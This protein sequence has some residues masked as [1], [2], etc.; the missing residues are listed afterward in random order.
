MSKLI[1]DMA[2]KAKKNTHSFLKTKKGKYS[3]GTYLKY[4]GYALLGIFALLAAILLF[5]LST[6]PL[7]DI[8]NFDKRVIS[9]S[10]KIYDRTGKILLYDN[11]NT[12]RR[13]VVDLDK[14][15]K[16]IANAAISI[17]DD[18][19]Y[20]H[21][22]IRI[23]SIVRAVIYTVF[24]GETQGGSTLTQQIVK[25]TLLTQDQTLSRKIKEAIIALRLEQKLTKDEILEIYLNE[26]PY[27]GNVYGVEE[28]SEVYFNKHASD[29][30]L[31]EA[32]YLASIPQSPY[33]YNPNGEHRD[34][35]DVRAHYVLKRMEEF[36][37]ITK[38][39]HAAAL[40]EDVYF[41]PK[42]Q[43]AVKAPHFVFY[44]RD[45]LEKKYGIERVDKEGLKVTSTLDFELQSV[46]EEEAKKEGLKNEKD[47]GGENVALVAIEPSSG[48]ILAM[49][50]SRDFFD[51]EIDGQFNVAT[52]ARQPGSSFKPFVYAT[53]FKKGYR[54]ET[55]LFDVFTE[56]NAN[57]TATGSGND[58][59]SPENFDAKFKGPMMLKNALAESRNIPAVKLLYLAGIQD[60]IATAK[61]MGITTLNNPKLYGLSLVLGAGEVKPIDMASAYAVFATG[62]IRHQSTG[63]LKVEDMQGNI[64]EEFKQD[65]GEQVL[66]D[67]VASAISQILSSEDLRAPT[68]GR[69]SSLHVPG[70]S[71]A[72]KTGTTNSNRDAWIV[73]Y[74]PKIA[75]AAW[76]GNNDNRAMKKGG[77]QLAGPLFNKVM[78]KYLQD[79]GENE[80]FP[81]IPLPETGGAPMLRGLW[82]GG[83]SFYIDSISGG[84]ATDFTPK[85]A[86]IEKVITNVHSIL[87]WVDK[88]NPLGERPSNPAKDPQFT[89][90]E[91]GVQRWLSGHGVPIITPAN[92]PTYYDNVHQSRVEIYASILG[93]DAE[94]E[95]TPGE[96]AQITITA[97]PNV[98]NKVDI[99][100]DSTRVATLSSAPW[101]Y[102][103]DPE[104]LKLKDGA[105]TLRIAVFDN[106]LNKGEDVIS[107]SYIKT[108]IP[109]EEE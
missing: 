38:E 92:M 73:G 94:K 22:G 14:I 64:L 1:K 59:Y 85:D 72:V 77:A 101:Q 26:A 108:P 48:Q 46:A 79:H 62:G 81:V 106:L 57:C 83:E 45:Y 51:T 95:F 97:Q 50:G 56:F 29:V 13:T 89:N 2:R 100:I 52:A 102:T 55:V 98:I 103:L 8:S 10:T 7:P 65:D 19:F 96:Q 87:Y 107:F 31:M 15:N 49:V 21:K 35:L 75:V 67:Y 82:Q 36:G 78:T 70:Y 43:S 69:G 9:Q 76:A 4:A 16:N 66:P 24:K 58:C 40:A 11:H 41:V 33:Y 88:D 27:S 5:Y 60:S 6:V 47:Y 86:L 109:A 44:I 25:N 54:P 37:Y 3:I 104:V 99:Y 84:L 42:A 90:W 39:E 63:I 71:V 80:P 53:A 61:S 34:E 32:A 20:N 91:Y 23:K 28:A 105:H 93:L 30:T 74:N 68:F 12:I 17:E 18:Q